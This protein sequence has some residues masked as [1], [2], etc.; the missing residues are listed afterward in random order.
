MFLVTLFGGLDWMVSESVMT[1]CEWWQARFLC[2]H[3]GHRLLYSAGGGYQLKDVLIVRGNKGRTAKLLVTSVNDDGAIK[4][5]E[6][7]GENADGHESGAGAA[8]RL[9]NSAQLFATDEIQAGDYEV[10][11]KSHPPYIVR[12]HVRQHDV[13]VGSSSSSGPIATTA[14]K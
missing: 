1:D 12:V 10:L 4:G 2:G 14:G 6:I 11:F 9:T 8:F 7:A 5:V 3:A 13:Q